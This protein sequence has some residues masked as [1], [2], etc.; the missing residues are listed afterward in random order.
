[1]ERDALIARETLI[2]RMAAALDATFQEFPRNRATRFRVY[3][4][5]CFDMARIDE[6]MDKEAVLLAF[7]QAAA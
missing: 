3:A 4:L 2:A 1:M 6:D 5:I 7:P